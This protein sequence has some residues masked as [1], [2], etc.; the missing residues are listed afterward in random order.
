MADLVVP[1]EHHVDQ[2]I[3]SV[4]QELLSELGGRLNRL[5]AKV[6]EVRDEADR[7]IRDSTRTPWGMVGVIIALFIAIIGGFWQ[8]VNIRFYASESSLI[9]L[10]AEIKA[11]TNEAV[12]RSEL[13]ATKESLAKDIRDIDRRSDELHA[14]ING[15]NAELIRRRTEFVEKVEL[16]ALE[17]RIDEKNFTQDRRAETFLSKDSWAAWK[18]ERDKLIDAMQ[19]SIRRL[20]Q[21]P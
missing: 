15:I 5:D 13:A 21:K 1:L 3:A 17:K 4:R 19:A 2:V 14:D 7:R 11:E 12:R 20:E 16:D 10:R 8:L 6:D 18:V 9:E